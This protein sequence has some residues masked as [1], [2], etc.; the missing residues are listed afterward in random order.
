MKNNCAERI[1]GEIS[2]AE[3][4]GRGEG[5]RTNWR[6]QFQPCSR[7]H[8]D[9]RWSVPWRALGSLCCWGPQQPPPQLQTPWS[10]HSGGSC[11]ACMLS[12]LGESHYRAPKGASVALPQSCQQPPS[13]Y[14]PGTP[15]PW[16]L[17]LYLCS[18][19]QL[20]HSSVL[21]C[22]PDDSSAP[23]S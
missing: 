2:L 16:L 1:A 19:L 21:T 4:S 23:V 12:P 11:S 5:Q 15:E 10:C 6:W 22:A 20:R 7:C 9:V 8:F 14:T 13:K 18:R 17:H 3:R